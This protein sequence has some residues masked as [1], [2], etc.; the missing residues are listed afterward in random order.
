[1]FN[2]NTKVVSEVIHQYQNL[3][4]NKT[5][6]SSINI[7]DLIQDQSVSEASTYHLFSN[8]DSLNK[9]RKNKLDT[10]LF[11][12]KFGNQPVWMPNKFKRTKKSEVA[13]TIDEVNR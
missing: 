9:F 4:S 8:P 11:V 13:D 1:M 6:N 10:S 5:H 3:L 7:E 2:K 12:N